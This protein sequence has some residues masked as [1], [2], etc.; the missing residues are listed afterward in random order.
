MQFWQRFGHNPSSREIR[1]QGLIRLYLLIEPDL[2]N[3]EALGE[4]M[5]EAHSMNPVKV[6]AM[7]RQLGG[8]PKHLFL[9][10]CEPLVLETENGY[11]GLSE[12]LKPVVDEAIVMIKSLIENID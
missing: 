1:I 9:V 12:P 5:I 6:L 8:Q 10:G 3:L 2:S 4:E 7:V 11:I